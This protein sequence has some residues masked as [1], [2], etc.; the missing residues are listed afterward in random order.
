MFRKKELPY[1]RE[2]YNY[3]EYYVLSPEELGELKGVNV[4]FHGIMGFKP[5][6]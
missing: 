6:I 5:V 1:P 4:K 2:S 3:D